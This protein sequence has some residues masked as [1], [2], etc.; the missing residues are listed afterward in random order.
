MQLEHLLAHSI[1]FMLEL[2]LLVS[3]ILS[4]FRLL[5]GAQYLLKLHDVVILVGIDQVGHGQYLPVILVGL[6]LLSIKGIHAALHQHVGQYQILQTLNTP[7]CTSLIVVLEGLCTSG[8]DISAALCFSGSES[9][10][11][12]PSRHSC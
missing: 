2:V 8:P 12:H 9:A 3:I 10:A 4:M 11:L 6:G 1:E 7:H 5:V